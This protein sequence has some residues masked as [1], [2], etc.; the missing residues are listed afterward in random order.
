M[1]ESSHHLLLDSPT[2]S[3]CHPGHCIALN[4]YTSSPSPFLCLFVKQFEPILISCFSSSASWHVKVLI[5]MQDEDFGLKSSPGQT[6][7]HDMSL[8]QTVIHSVMS[9]FIFHHICYIKLYDICSLLSVNVREE[10][11]ALSNMNQKPFSGLHKFPCLEL[12]CLPQSSC[13]N[14]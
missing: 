12:I 5:E 10:R 11:P 2:A 14:P 7:H 8:I 3:I 6:S 4:K 9:R 13:Q 1:L